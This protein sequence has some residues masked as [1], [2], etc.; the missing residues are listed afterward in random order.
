MAKYQTN[1]SDVAL[2]LDLTQALDETDELCD[3]NPTS[4]VYAFKKLIT[5][6]I[7]F[8]VFK[9]YEKLSH[10]AFRGDSK[11]FLTYAGVSAEWDELL[12]KGS[13][14]KTFE[15]V[16]ENKKQALTLLL[17]NTKM[18]N[19]AARLMDLIDDADSSRNLVLCVSAHTRPD[20]SIEKL[21]EQI[22][23]NQI[24]RKIP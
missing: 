11:A 17:Q 21:K 10:S 1:A 20:A 18:I 14:V 5:N 23:Q 15:D 6:S 19:D 13:Q 24:S 16:N 7:H 4:I 3:K 12:Q 8:S 9:D 2:L 22:L